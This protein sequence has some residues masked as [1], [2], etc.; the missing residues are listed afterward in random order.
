MNILLVDDERDSRR[1]VAEFLQELG[2][3]VDEADNGQSA[4]AWLE[5][6]RY[7]LVLSDIRMPE[8][9]GTELLRRIRDRFPDHSLEVV[10][11]TGFATM[12]TALE[13]LRAGAYDYLM[14]PI[15]IDELVHIVHRIADLHALKAENQRL[16]DHFQEELDQATLATRAELDQF[17]LAF[18]EQVGLGSVVIRSTAMKG[19]IHQAFQLHATRNVPA[20]IQGET[21][22][23]KELIA[24]AIHYGQT[25][26]TAPFVGINC[27]A[28]SP[29]LF[30]SELFGY[31]AGA[32]TGAQ[33]RGQK[34]KL[35]LAEGGTLFLDEI[36]E[37]PL[38]LQAK[39]LRFLQERE[40]Y[41][42]GGLKRIQANVRIVCA[43]NTDLETQVAHGTFRQDL[44]YRLSIAKILLPPLRERKDD[45][46]PLAASFLSS[47]ALEYKKPFHR[48]SPECERVLLDYPW[49]GNVRELRNIIEWAVIMNDGE[50]LT[51]GHLKLTG[52]MHQGPAAGAPANA[53]LHHEQFELP[54]QELPLDRF[55]HNIIEK[56]LEKHG[57]NKSETARYL[58][59]TRRTLYSRLSSGRESSDP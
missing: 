48:I 53:T 5:Q 28:L 1:S 40:Y 13:A 18:L 10:L 31:E 25:G 41:R 43:T 9:S 11:F 17:R 23:G 37:I 7:H 15:Q 6:R 36:S 12:D 50:T 54:A 42:V 59:M 2:H 51:P 27:A 14:K 26:S 49:P 58:G 24:R 21:G 16:T 8:M 45:I 47:F 34:G 56:A 38:G 30:E 3:D 46:L 33:A 35:D 44:Y 57:G 52:A 22:T 19:A 55:M 4:L 29:T 39:L 20:L 32:F